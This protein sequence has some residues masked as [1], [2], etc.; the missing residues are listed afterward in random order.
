MCIRD[1]HG[2][3]QREQRGVLTDRHDLTLARRPVERR[4]VEAEDRDLAGKRF[5]HG[6]LP[7]KM[8]RLD[9]RGWLPDRLAPGRKYASRGDDVVQ[10]HELLAV[11]VRHGTR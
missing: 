5:C 10:D 4:K 1:R 2:A 11:L 8:T 9:G 3:E 6:G 7:P